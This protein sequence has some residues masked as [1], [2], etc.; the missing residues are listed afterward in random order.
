MKSMQDILST[1]HIDTLVY[2][3]DELGKS[4]YYDNAKGKI[5]LAISDGLQNEDYPFFSNIEVW[6]EEFEKWWNHAYFEDVM[7]LARM[8]DIQRSLPN[9]AT[10]LL[11]LMPQ[12]FNVDLLAPEQFDDTYKQNLINNLDQ[13]KKFAII[14]VDYDLNG[15]SVN[16]DYL[17]A[18][19]GYQKNVYC[20]IF[21]QTFDV[22][23]EIR[24][25]QE[26]SFNKN[27]YPL[28]K[29]RFDEDATNASIIQGIK[30]VVWLK[31]IGFIKETANKVAH[32]ALSILEDGLREIDPATFDRMVIA[33]AKA[34]G[35]WEFE[36]LLRIIQIYINKGIRDEIRKM[37]PDF[38]ASTK[39]LR[40]FSDSSQIENVN[41]EL[42]K[43][44][45]EEEFYE[46]VDYVNGVYS[47]V[48][49]GDIFQIGDKYYM[50][51]GQPCNLAIR[52]GKRANQLDQAYLIP[53]ISETGKDMCGK[54]QYPYEDIYR[55]ALFTRRRRVSL[56]LL[57][58]VS[59]NDN[60]LAKIDLNVAK[61]TIAG[62]EMMQEN[63]L[64]R[65]EK[66][67]ERVR[68]YYKAYNLV[69]LGKSKEEK[70]QIATFF[71]KPFEM[72]EAPI[73][74]KP[75]IIGTTITFQVKRVGRYYAYGA[76][77]LLQQFMSYMSRPEFPVD[78]NRC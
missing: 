66:I 49:N 62:H 33:S 37:F 60:G 1:Q 15:Y 25:W 27:I 74:K 10:K 39:S 55:F 4:S 7:T 36:N 54:L 78:F 34:E 29:K 73:A 67:R 18:N 64:L 50:L 28:S 48:S 70:N 46:N 20:G 26:R 16:G 77:V 47:A 61:E 21:S 75:T 3:D 53:L 56:S 13:C 68:G 57:D 59:Y 71:C 23:D 31:Q 24:K 30:N 72:G 41:S 22:N 9:I 5:R 65:Y 32:N 51:L 8:Y 17:L 44:I 52:E 38:Q 42:L 12:N 35:C 58:L 19:I 69:S 14:L 2:V 6:E 63:M 76:H 43:S 45:Q 40:N 11:E